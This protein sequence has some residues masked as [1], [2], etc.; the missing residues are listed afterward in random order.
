MTAARRGGILEVALREVTWMWRDKVALLVVLAVPLLAF[1]ILATTFSNAVIRDLNVDVVDQ[2]RTPTSQTFAQAVSSAPG[3]TVAQR[4]SDLNGAMHAIRS[5]RAIAAVFIP[6]NLERDILEGRRPQVVI[7]YNKQFFTPGNVAS[8]ALQSAISAAVATLP[9]RQ[10]STAFVPGPLVVEQYVLFNPALNYAQFLLRSILPTV[11]HVVIAIAG[12]YAVGSEFASRSLA[13][14][15]EAAGGSPLSAL[16]GKLVPYLAI[17]LLMMCVGL[18]IIHGVYQVQFRGSSP[19]IMGAAATLLIIAYWS[20]GAL[21]QLLVKNLAL[22]LSLTAIVCSPAFG[23]AGVGFPILAMGSFARGWGAILPLRWYIQILFDQA[24]RGVPPAYSVWPLLALA[25]LALVYFGLGALRLR[26]LARHPAPPAPVQPVEQPGSHAGFVQAFAD[27]YRR[28]LGDKG[29]FG[30][31]V[32]APII[33]GVFYPQPYFGQLVKDTPIAVV[34]DDHTDLSRNIIQA[35]D[36]DEAIAVAAQPST[37]SEAQTALERRELFGILSIPAGTERE[38]FKGEPARLPA[39]VDSA[40]F[41][42][43]RGTLQGIQEG[44]GAVR[45]DL[46]ARSARP[47][48]SLYRA[49]LSKSSPVEIL[50]QPLFN[51]TGGYGSYVVPAAFLLILQQTLLMGAATLSGVAYEQGGQVAQRRRGGVAAVLAQALAHLLLVLPGFALYLVV[52]PRLYGFSANDRVLDLLVLAIP[53]ILSVSFLGQFIGSWFKRRETAVLLLIAVSLPLFFLVGVAWPPEAI[54]PALRTASFVFPSTSGI[55]AL[56][57]V[58]QMGASFGDVFHDW[59]RLWLLTA[60]YAVLAIGAS[61]LSAA[62]A[63]RHG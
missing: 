15:L 22:G 63:S 1:A 8:G 33:Y 50:N 40:Y 56:V 16:V 49:A 58:N 55:D 14:W 17:F 48:G 45:A 20:V 44:V 43:F 2:D 18:G 5:G 39:F 51:P 23:F 11:L 4:S 6:Q 38:V 47:D 9:G 10:R 52:L 26:S 41:L 37:L 24:A 35:L 54:P 36:A 30:L 3:V 27:E 31:I 46:A 7:F 59:T 19:T 13:E 25:G 61:R 21:F 53:F 28:V 12:G 62:G 57:R 32:L 34:D 42:L 29:V 60:I